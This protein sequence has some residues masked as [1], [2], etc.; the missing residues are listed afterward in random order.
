[1]APK[2]DFCKNFMDQEVETI[3]DEEE[4][5]LDERESLRNVFRRR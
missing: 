1:M 4:L 2:V 5:A 3:G